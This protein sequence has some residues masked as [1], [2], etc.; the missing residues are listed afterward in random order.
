VVVAAVGAHLGGD[1]DGER[2]HAARQLGQHRAD[3]VAG[4]FGVEVARG[5][6]RRPAVV[7]RLHHADQLRRRLH[8][9]LILGAATVALG[10]LAALL[11]PGRR[12]ARAALDPALAAA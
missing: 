12:T 9:A 2:V 11:V 3:V 1:G 8:P 10:A 5:R 6:E 7:G 4:A